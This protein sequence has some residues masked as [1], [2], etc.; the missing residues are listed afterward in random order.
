MLNKQFESRCISAS[1]FMTRCIQ[2]QFMHQ[3]SLEVVAVFIS[4][5]VFHTQ[6]S[7]RNMLSWYH[8]LN[9]EILKN[10]WRIWFLIDCGL[11]VYW[12]AGADIWV[13]HWLSESWLHW[14]TF[15]RQ[16]CINLYSAKPN[17]NNSYVYNVQ[18]GSFFSSLVII[19]VCIALDV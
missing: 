16:T 19:S 18:L 15:K 5:P 17:L 3:Q 7:T 1:W 4:F 9:F 11:K 10:F 12:I 13:R 8:C 14:K 2:R 6:T